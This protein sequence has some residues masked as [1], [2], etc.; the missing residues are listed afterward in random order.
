MVYVGHGIEPL[1]SFI[2]MIMLQPQ[3]Q[4][5]SVCTRG[6]LVVEVRCTEKKLSS[7]ITQEAILMHNISDCFCT[8]RKSSSLLR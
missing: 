1:T 6:R 2:T 5:H 4:W 7:V 3:T 8:C